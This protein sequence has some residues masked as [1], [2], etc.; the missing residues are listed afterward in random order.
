MCIHACVGQNSVCV[1]VCV[2]VF[3][4]RHKYTY[5]VNMAVTGDYRCVRKGGG[6]GASELRIYLYLK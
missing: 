5:V 1:R 6:G 4:H 3:W 2:C